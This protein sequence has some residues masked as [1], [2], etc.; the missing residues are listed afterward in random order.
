MPS[1]MMSR[2]RLITFLGA[3]SLGVFGQACLQSFASTSD[4][5]L[6]NE[7]FRVSD[8]QKIY[9]PSVGEKEKWYIND[10]TFVQST[11]GLWHLFGITHPEPAS[12]AQERFFAHATAK[13]L[14]GPWTKQAPILPV[15]SR[16]NETVVW[17]PFVLEHGGRYW[18]YYCGGG[19]DHSKYRIQLA[20]S[21]NLWCWQ[22]SVVN[23]MVVDGVDARDPMVLLVGDEWV[24]YY[25]ATSTPRGG[26]HTVL[27]VTSKDL[28]RWSGRR[29]V[30]RSRTKGTYGGDTESP[31]VV[32]RNGKYYLFVCTNVNYNQT[33]VYESTSPFHWDLE[34][35][36]GTYPAHASEIIHAPN[37]RW[38]AS[39]CGWGEG[40]VYLAELKWL[41]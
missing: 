1:I 5:R 36:V 4:N 24:M 16:Q 27:S 40:G 10:H 25:A 20:K 2:R 8:F 38:Y 31:F 19:V 28:V 15:D 30:F 22:R 17:A 41:R 11:D 21:A 35:V 39:R 26:F 7:V 29:E 9:D 18:M 34:Q 12:P 33:A 14:M 13:N 23:P 32:A 37:G 6:G 3:T